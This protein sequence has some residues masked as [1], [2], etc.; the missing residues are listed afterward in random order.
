[1]RYYKVYA[2]ASLSTERNSLL[3]IFNLTLALLGEHLGI[4]LFTNEERQ[5]VE[6]MF[7][8]DIRDYK[9]CYQMA[10][11]EFSD[12]VCHMIEN[13]EVTIIDKADV[14]TDFKPDCKILIYTPAEQLLSF[15]PSLIEW[16]VTN[17]MKSV[18]NRDELVDALFTQ[19][20]L[21]CTDH[22]GHHIRIP[23]AQNPDHNPFFYGIRA[24]IFGDIIS[25]SIC[26]ETDSDYFMCTD[27]VPDKFFL[28]LV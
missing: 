19:K 17:K 5:K 3:V 10:V 22:K 18:R 14:K 21:K 6:E 26:K 15:E 7:H 16:I 13:N 28:P 23:T 25:E 4:D 24:D 2:D 9:T 8:C 1:M 20:Q 27:E 11:E 12:I